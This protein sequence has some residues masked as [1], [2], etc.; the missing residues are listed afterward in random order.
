MTLK[1]Y[2]VFQKNQK[3]RTL[4][5]Y[6]KTYIKRKIRNFYALLLEVLRYLN[7]HRISNLIFAYSFIRL[8]EPFLLAFYYMFLANPSFTLLFYCSPFCTFSTQIYF[9]YQTLFFPTIKIPIH[10]KSLPMTSKKIASPTSFYTSA[11]R[12]VSLKH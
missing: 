12:S 6:K 11:T 9:N 7:C 3:S 4:P 1:S 10:S 5:Y 2:K 8:V